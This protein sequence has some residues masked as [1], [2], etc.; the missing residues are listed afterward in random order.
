MRLHRNSCFTIWPLCRDHNNSA[1]SESHDELRDR[2]SSAMQK[3]FTDIEVTREST[4]ENTTAPP[5]HLT[6]KAK[7]THFK[8]GDIKVAE[9]ELTFP[10]DCAITTCTLSQ[11]I[12]PYRV[13]RSR[14]NNNNTNDEAPS[15]KVD[16]TL[17]A[18]SAKAVDKSLCTRTNRASSPSSQ[19]P[20]V[21]WT[22]RQRIASNPAATITTPKNTEPRAGC[23]PDLRNQVRLRRD[24]E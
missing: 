21:D 7:A 3:E 4:V 23:N 2:S 1:R 19:Q 13:P 6:I 15:Y 20:R 9:P 5:S 24:S 14:I 10:I 12:D 22:R 17:Y 11:A 8:R 18:T 16:D